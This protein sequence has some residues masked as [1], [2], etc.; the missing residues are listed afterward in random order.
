MLSRR[1]DSPRP[2]GPAIAGERD[3]PN[4]IAPAESLLQDDFEDFL[5]GRKVLLDAPVSQSVEFY[6]MG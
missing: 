1:R 2:A 4:D 3:T 5:K 6:L